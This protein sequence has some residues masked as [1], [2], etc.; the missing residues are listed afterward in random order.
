MSKHM[1][2]VCNKPVKYYRGQCDCEGKQIDPDTYECHGC[3]FF[4]SEHIRHPEEN[5][6]KD[7]KRI[8]SKEQG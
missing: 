3:G 4:Y 6:A 1:C 2:A 7:Y 5:Q 8:L